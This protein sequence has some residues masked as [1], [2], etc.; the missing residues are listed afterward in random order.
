M[1]TSRTFSLVSCMFLGLFLL[2]GPAAGPGQ[3]FAQSTIITDE[4]ALFGEDAPDTLDPVPAP[5]GGAADAA[6]PVSPTAPGSGSN[7]TAT[8]LKSD[9]VR[10]GGS[11]TGKLESSFSWTNPYEG[12][13]DPL[14]PDSSSIDPTIASTIFFNARPEEDLRIYGSV[15]TAWPFINTATFLTSKDYYK[16]PT[17]NVAVLSKDISTINIQV[18]ELFSD[19]TWNDRA[20][21]RFGKH[22]VKWGV[23]YFFSPAD[24]L[25]LTPIDVMD[26]T[27]QR[28]GPI[29][30][31]ALVPIPGTQN[32]LWGYLLLPGSSSSGSFKPE[33]L[34]YAGKAEFLLANTEIGLGGFYQK[35]MAPR[36]IGTA[37]GSLGRLDLF[38]EAVVSWGNDRQYITALTP[39]PAFETRDDRWY[40][41]GTAGLLYTARDGY[42]SLAAQYYY[43]GEGY[44]YDERNDLVDQFNALP[45]AT[46]E[47]LSYTLIGNSGILI[48]HP[49]RSPLR[50]KP[51]LWGPVGFPVRTVY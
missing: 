6:S 42:T 38:A 33:E 18:F 28:E 31:R 25:N 3:L 9:Q 50:G 2:L 39:S 43:N 23:G 16:V 26:P 41:Q 21:F 45:S 29:S 15:K 51:A 35:D 8:F 11:F 10:I 14:N 5:A 48:F 20:Y 27:A 13:H 12:N 46:Q 22:T 40:F 24:V 36:F 47:D 34:A 7:V 37:S 19:F 17:S 49:N 32:N 1:K 30:L 4:E 44:P